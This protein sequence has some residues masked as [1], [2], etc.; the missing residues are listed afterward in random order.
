MEVVQAP[1]RAREG[2]APVERT[3]DEDHGGG[4]AVGVTSMVDDVQAVRERAQRL[5]TGAQP[6][7]DTVMATNMV[8][9]PN[10]WC[11]WASPQGA[12]VRS[13]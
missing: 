8:R 12:P 13:M 3:V 7:S 2:R 10:A 1:D 9:H 5:V 11:A 6:G 4:G